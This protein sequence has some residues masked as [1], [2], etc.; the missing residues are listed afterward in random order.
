M[1]KI[2][3][4]FF[5]PHS[6]LILMILGFL[7]DRP[8]LFF[9]L[10][11]LLLGLYTIGDFFFKPDEVFLFDDILSTTENDGR[12]SPPFFEIA[13]GSYAILHVICLGLGLYFVQFDSPIWFL[14]LIPM[15]HSTNISIALQHE[16]VHKTNLVEKSVGRFLGSLTFWS[17]HEF[18]HLYSHHNSDTICT[19]TDV[20][21]SRFN[22][23]LYSYIGLTIIDNFKCAH[24]KQNEICELAGTSF[25]NVFKNAF[26]G[27]ILVSFLIAISILIFIG[28]KALA[29]F[30]IQAV[31]GVFLYLSGTYTQH[32]GLTR[33]VDSNGDTEP[34]TYMNIWSAKHYISNRILFNGEH[35]GHHHMFQL[36]RYPHLKVIRTGPLLPYGYSTLFFLTLVP[37]LWYKIMN[38]LVNKAFEDLDRYKKDNSF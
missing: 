37:P 8:I 3:L 24:A 1:K 31:L 17:Y 21:S 25:Y 10:I 11:I 26:I 6:M 34:F 35:H 19:E 22:Q 32:Y 14:Y 12:R 30:I 27:W 36:C 38:P 33:R 4:S 16:Y 2:D 15:I 9:I 20:S 5:I 13:L 7:T 18:Q 29:F 23:S 28:P